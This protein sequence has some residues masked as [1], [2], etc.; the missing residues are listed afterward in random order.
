MAK[1][2]KK[3]IREHGRALALDVLGKEQFNKNKVAR[4]EI[5]SHFETGALWAEFALNLK[6]KTKK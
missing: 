2:T 3:E 1:L 6:N 5:M 4:D